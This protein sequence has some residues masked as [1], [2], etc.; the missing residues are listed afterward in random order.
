MPR[1]PDLGNRTGEG[2]EMTDPAYVR[3]VD[4]GVAELQLGLVNP[5][6]LSIESVEQIEA[7]QLLLLEAKAIVE[8]QAHD[9]DCRVCKR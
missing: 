6:V 8:H 1:V 5:F 9:N 2:E 4:D 7:L 3:H